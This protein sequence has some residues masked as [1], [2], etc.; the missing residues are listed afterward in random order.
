R[1]WS[2]EHGWCFDVLDGPLGDDATLRPN[3]IFAVALP[4]EVLDP[5]R[6]RAIVD[7]CASRLWTPAGL[8]TLAPDDARYVGHY[9]GDRRARDGAYH[10]GTAWTWLAGPF[11][12]A[13]ARAY[14]DKAAARALLDACADGLSADALGTLAEIADGDPPFTARGAFAQAWS[15]ATVL[16][17]WTLLA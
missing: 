14:G 1:F 15:V 10:M 4:I 12:L 6:R 2:A 13:Y 16:D 11:A 17:A 7:V 5:P 9:G 8:R 3:Q